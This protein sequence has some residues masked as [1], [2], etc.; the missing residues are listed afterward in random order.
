MIWEDHPP[1]CPWSDTSLRWR[2]L[3][4]WWGLCD[5]AGDWKSALAL[6]LR[7]FGLV[8]ASELLR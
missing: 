3:E 7:F 1:T 5:E 8:K 4:S 2:M 6:W